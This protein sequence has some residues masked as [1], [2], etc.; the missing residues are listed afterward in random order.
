LTRIK[1][2]AAALCFGF[3]KISHTKRSLAMVDIKSSPQQIRSASPELRRRLGYE[4]SRVLV[5]ENALNPE[6][7]FPKPAGAA[8]ALR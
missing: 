2:V 5:E 6:R 8:G 1:A 4:V 3:V 7:A